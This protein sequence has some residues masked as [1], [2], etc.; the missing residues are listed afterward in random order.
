MSEREA[1]RA[2][3]FAEACHEGQFRRFTGEPYINHPRRVAAQALR[4]GLTDEGVAAAFLHDVVEDCG[5]TLEEIEKY[6]GSSLRNM[7]YALSDLQTPEDGNRKERHKAHLAK[8]SGTGDWEIQTL[9]ILDITDN[10]RTLIGFDPRFWH[11]A[12]KDEAM[13]SIASLD[14]ADSEAVKQLS[15]ILT[16][17]K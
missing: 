11:S 3:L 7:V 13:D 12:A 15:E 6:F 2:M 5:V 16:G 17:K 8:I 4:L 1:F 9:A 10:A 14:Q